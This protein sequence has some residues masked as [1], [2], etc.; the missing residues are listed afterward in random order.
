MKIWNYI[1][2]SNFIQD[3]C[4]EVKRYKHKKRGKDGNGRD[5]EFTEE[6]KK[7]IREGLKKLFNDLK[8]ME[9]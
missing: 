7:Q 6:D 5:I 1:T 2:A 9:I 3:Y 8:K 4:K